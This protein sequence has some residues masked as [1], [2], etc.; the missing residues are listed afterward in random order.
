MCCNPQSMSN[1]VVSWF[2]FLLNLGPMIPTQGVPGILSSS[3]TVANHPL[4]FDFVGSG[5]ECNSAS[6]SLLFGIALSSRA[7]T[8][9]KLLFPLLLGTNPYEKSPTAPL[10]CLSRFVSLGYCLFSLFP[11]HNLH[12]PGNYCGWT[13]VVIMVSFIE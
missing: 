11:L 13:R 10:S 7:V 9:L 8:C 6:M 2:L 4:I 5:T 1:F 3:S 12:L